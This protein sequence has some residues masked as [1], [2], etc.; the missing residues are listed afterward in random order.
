[1]LGQN[2]HFANYAPEK[3]PYAIERYVKETARLYGVLKKRLSEPLEEGLRQREY[4]AGN[5]SIADITCY[6]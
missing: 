3:I 2:Y 5:Y 6:P 4:V 1:M